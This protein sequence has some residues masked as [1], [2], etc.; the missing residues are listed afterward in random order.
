MTA[1]R[2]ENSAYAYMS[3]ICTRHQPDC[4]VDCTVLCI[5]AFEID[6]SVAGRFQGMIRRKQTAID[7]SNLKARDIMPYTVYIYDMTECMCHRGQ[8]D[9]DHQFVSG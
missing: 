2:R 5:A 9:Y 7:Q 6:W 3:I 8:P 1:P 4:A